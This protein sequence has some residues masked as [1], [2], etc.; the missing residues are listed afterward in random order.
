[1]KQPPAPRPRPPLSV[2]TL[3]V[4]PELLRGGRGPASAPNAALAQE[5]HPTPPGGS[6]FAT[7]SFTTP[8]RQAVWN[9]YDALEAEAL[10]REAAWRARQLRDD[11]VVEDAPLGSFLDPERLGE[12]DL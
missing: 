1:M 5:A 2:T 12:H 7:S 4:G 3:S 11:P 6:S 8:E 9:V 10:E